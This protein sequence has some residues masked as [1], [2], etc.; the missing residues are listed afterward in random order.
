MASSFSPFLSPPAKRPV[1][2]STILPDPNP[3]STNGY[4]ANKRSKPHPSTSAA[5]SPVPSGNVLFRLLCHESR[6]GG[7]IGKGGNIIK[8]LQQQ[9]GAKIRIEDAPLESPDRVITIVGSVTQSSVVFSGIE[10]AIEVSQGQEALVR[11]FERI[12]EVAAESDSVAGG[13]V[14]CRLLAEISSV[15]AV[16]GKGGK[17]VEKI[18]KDCGCKVKVLIDKL[19]VCASSN[20]EM[21]EIEGDVSAVKKGLV[22]VSH[23]LQDCQPVDKT[24]VISSKPVEALSRVSFPE[25]GVEVRPQHSAVRPTIAQHSV[26]PPTVT[27]SSIDYAS[28]SHLFSLEPE[29]VSTLDTSTPQQQVVFR[30]L[31]N[32]DRVGGVIGKGGNIVTALQNETGATISI[33]PKVAGCDERLITV[34]ASENPESRYSAAQKTVVLVFSRVV[35]SVIEKGLDPGSS[36]G[37]PVSVRLVVSPNQ[38]GCLLG[39]GGT[40]ISEMRKATSTSIRIIG[41]DQGNPKCV[42]ETDHV[43][44]ILGDFLNVKDSIY[45]ITGRLRDNLFSSILG[46]PGARSSSSVLAETSPYVRLMDPVRDAK[47]DLL[48]DPS[49][50]PLRDIMR[51]PWRDPQRDIM[52]DPLRDPQRDIMR[53]PLRDP[54]RDEFRDSLRETVREPVRDPLR[55]PG[56]GPSRELGRDSA[57]F[58]QPVVGIS[59]NLNRQ[60]VITQSMDH[61][62]F[63]RNLDHSPSPRLWGSQTIP[64]VNPRGISDLSG[65]LPSFKSGLDFVSGGKSVFV[66]NTTVEIVVPE[67]AFGSVY[68][69]NGSNLARLRQF[70]GAKVIVHEPRLGTSDRVIVISGTPDETQAAQSLLHAFILTGQY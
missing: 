5:P 47:R 41:H 55:G 13:L 17:T 58:L 3:N 24:R 50:E 26:A 16:I 31:C 69:E 23:R 9:T 2:Y 62:G 29:R 64:G 27:N 12:L 38:V 21:I 51:D 30:I 8:G 68:G 70:S 10:S 53:D 59:H 40:I 61:L 65:E 33:G 20:E 7:I 44:E 37:S 35:E 56:R 54:L 18:R 19:P 15:G 67:H 63:S 25:V 57:S 39:K 28:G 1:Y 34:T 32:N 42:P 43:V 60:T 66:T 52:R 46:T 22:A 45:H 48:R 6:I 11:V 36:E 49:W 4:S 14:S